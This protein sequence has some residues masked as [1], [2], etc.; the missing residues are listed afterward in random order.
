[1]FIELVFSYFSFICLYLY[2]FC[3]I[4]T[5]FNFF[6]VDLFVKLFC[7]AGDTVKVD[8]PAR[9]QVKVSL[10]ASPMTFEDI[11]SVSILQQ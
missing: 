7:R 6:C 11:R 2:S 4:L 10:K 8:E 9:D 3:N 5:Q 1:M